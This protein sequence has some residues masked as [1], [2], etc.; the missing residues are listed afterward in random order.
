[1]DHSSQG[2][3]QPDWGSLGTGGQAGQAI[4][5]MGISYG[6][7]L[8]AKNMPALFSWSR[9]HRLKYYFAVNNSYV[10]SK[11]KV[12]LLPCLH[13]DW[14]RKAHQAMTEQG[15]SIE[16]ETPKQ[17]INAPDLYIPT[18]A[19]VTFTLLMGYFLGVVG[20]FTPESLS[21]VASSTL[22]TLILEVL[23]FKVGFYLLD[24]RGQTPSIFDLVAFSGY[25]Y[26]GLIA[27][28]LVG[29]I[30]SG[31]IFFFAK[32]FCGGAMALFMMRTIK[33]AL[34]AGPIE[35]VNPLADANSASRRNY[36][37]II[38]GALQLLLTFFL[39]RSV[40]FNVAP[41]LVPVSPVAPTVV[42][43]VLS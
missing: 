33:Q 2:L 32:L 43:P 19:F 26:V 11:L 29:F 22:V 35:Q 28:I 7:D 36:F 15:P 21:L 13:K 9:L 5:A 16:F 3:Q 17:D 1:M 38:I 4:A 10:I 42:P 25:K 41:A 27:A 39:L 30:S 6:R 40:A 8:V 24:E 34:A 14:Q 31:W 12:L 23:L 37:L 20:K 18:M